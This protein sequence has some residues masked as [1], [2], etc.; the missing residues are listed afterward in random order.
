VC[1]HQTEWREGH[2]LRAALI[3]GLL[4]LPIVACGQDRRVAGLEDRTGGH[5]EV[6][7]VGGGVLLVA[8]R[9]NLVPQATSSEDER[10]DALSSLLIDESQRFS[11]NRFAEELAF[12]PVMAEGLFVID[13]ERLA[14]TLLVQTVDGAPVL[15]ALQS[16]A[17]AIGEDRRVGELRRVHAILYD[18]ARL[19]TPPAAPSPRRLDEARGA[20][21]SWLARE[22]GITDGEATLTGKRVI[23]ARLGV[24][25]YEARWFRAERGGAS[26][27]IVAILDAETLEPKLYLDED[28]CQAHLGGSA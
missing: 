15:E 17:W 24:A 6:L 8:E 9:G 2:G 5:V 19:P 11:A 14:S 1:F 20:F 16:G 28:S 18:P 26:S 13:G 7:D 4:V 3:C 21:E 22:R 10:I 27:R 25:G 23:S 12:E